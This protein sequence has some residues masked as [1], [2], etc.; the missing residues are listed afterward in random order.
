MS[1]IG[2]ALLNESQVLEQLAV[3]LG[4]L[5]IAGRKLLVIIPDNTRTA[6]VDLFFRMLHRLCADQVR[7]LDYLV[8]LG[9]HPLL[10]E[11]ELLRRV[12]ISREQK[13]GLYSRIGLFNHRWDRGDTFERIGSI[14]EAEME[15]LTGGVLREAMEVSINRKVFDYDRLLV[16]GPVY[17]HEIAGFSGYGKYLFPGI[18]GP[19]F[20]D[21]S[22][23]LGALQTN[24]ATIGVRDTPTRRLIDRATEMVP[25]PKTFLNLV[26][27]EEGLKG[28]FVGEDRSAWEA[29]VA[30]SQRLNVRYV[31]RPF[32]QVLS[33]ASEKYDDFW[34]GAKAF[35]KVEAIVA[36]GGELVVYAPH[37]DRISITHDE[38]LNRTGFHVKDYYLAHMDRYRGIRKGVLG[39]SSLVKG[40]GTY[41]DGV[42]RPRVR[43]AL[44][45]GVPREV[46]RR[47]NIDYRDPEQIRVAA[48]ANR[49]S[50]GIYVVHNAGEVLYRLRAD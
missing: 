27:D 37:I 17:P 4:G 2:K 47:L 18:C 12:G 19:E 46:C 30:L 20:I 29:A 49:E 42:E 21:V 9:T 5:D 22:H 34:T 48:W 39:Y 36:D 13:E 44:A 6:P 40:S 10:S 14:A 23:W 33:I 45:S 1:G 24:L 31:E 26:V 32:G 38:I 25:I 35:Y 28:L 7:Q 43:V 15:E 16:L 41:R 8:A 11:Q 3:S 50:E